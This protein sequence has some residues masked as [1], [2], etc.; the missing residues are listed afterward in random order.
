MVKSGLSTMRSYLTYIR[1]VFGY[2][3]YINRE[4]TVTDLDLYRRSIEN[5]TKCSL[6]QT[7]IHFVFGE[8]HPNAD[9]LFAGEAP[10]A[11]E[12]ETG[13]PFVG[14][15]GMLLETALKRI[16]LNRSQVF[17][18]NVLKCRPPGNRDPL[19]DEIALC[20]PYLH[21]Q[22][23]L[24]KPKVIVALGRIAGRTLL[25]LSPDTS[26]TAMR[27]E[28]HEY[29]HVPLRVFYHPA[30]ILRNAGRLDEFY[31]D[32]EKLAEQFLRK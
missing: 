4:Q 28:K 20:E 19:P 3:L 11:R 24:I 7:R 30:A 31:A 17:I 16:G 27:N 12:D 26:L 29:Q 14:R 5:C 25:K 10:G 2:E 6:S 22:I 13:H 8:G 18:A 23:E 1:D 21:R 32:F 15:A 9:I